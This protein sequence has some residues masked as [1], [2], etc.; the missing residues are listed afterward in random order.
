MKERRLFQF[1]NKPTVD[2][3]KDCREGREALREAMEG[4]SS[5]YTRCKITSTS[6]ER[7]S[8]EFQAAFENPT[9]CGNPSCLNL[10]QAIILGEEAPGIGDS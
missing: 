10:R 9:N 5:G 6:A 7:L 4:V 1:P 8:D 2:N 3:C